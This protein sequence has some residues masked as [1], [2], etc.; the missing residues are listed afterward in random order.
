M[1]NARKGD[2]L[3][4]CT[5]ITQTYQT[6][7][8]PLF[9]FIWNLLITQQQSWVG[10]VISKHDQQRKIGIGSRELDRARKKVFTEN[11]IEKEKV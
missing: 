10:V 3:I 6:M 1:D 7:S 9:L 5:Y 11:K 4:S 8:S 2:I